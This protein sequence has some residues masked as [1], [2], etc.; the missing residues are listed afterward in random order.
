MANHPAVTGQQKTHYRTS[1]RKDYRLTHT[2]E[3]K[4]APPPDRTF[5]LHADPSERDETRAVETR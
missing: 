2:V 5:V 1:Q 3:L 4:A